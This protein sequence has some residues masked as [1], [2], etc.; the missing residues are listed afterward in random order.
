MS[1]AQT[2]WLHSLLGWTEIGKGRDVVRVEN[3]NGDED[4]PR[5]RALPSTSTFL[6]SDGGEQP[7]LKRAKRCPSLLQLVGQ[8]WCRF[9]HWTHCLCV[10]HI[11]TARGVCVVALAQGRKVGRLDDPW[12]VP[13]PWWVLGAVDLPTAIHPWV[14][15][16]V[17]WR[18][19][20]VGR[21]L[22]TRIR[23]T[24]VNC[25]ASTAT[26]GLSNVTSSATPFINDKR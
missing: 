16:T 12:W 6:A 25:S 10:V 19:T 13:R 4:E 23:G 21:R 26:R 24:L 3:E 2:R 7:L 9:A 20:T 15:G 5:T 1:I 11:R 18:P 14:Q 8:L 17:G 22:P